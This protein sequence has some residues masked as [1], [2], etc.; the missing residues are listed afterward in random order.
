MADPD[1]E[2]AFRNG[3]FFDALDAVRQKRK[4]SWRAIAKET[5]VNASTLTRM[6]QGRRPDVDSFAALVAWAGL[7]ADEYLGVPDEQSAEAPL[8]KISVLLRHDPNLTPEAS[9]A[10]DE[11]IQITYDRLKQA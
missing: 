6:S 7:D 10:I 4:K 5:N 3:E 8:E 9:A 2:R 11:L 1:R